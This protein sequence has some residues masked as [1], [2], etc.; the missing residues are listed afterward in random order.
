M[1]WKSYLEGSESDEEIAIII[2]VNIITDINYIRQDRDIKA[3]IYLITTVKRSFSIIVIPIIPVTVN[4]IIEC[5]VLVDTGAELNMITIDVIDRAGL[6]M[7][8]R[9]KIKISLYS[10][11]INRFL[12]MIENMLISVGLVVYRV[13]I[14]VTRLISQPFILEIFYFYSAHAQLLFNNDLI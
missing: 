10:E 3:G 5:F 2:A 8:T 11:Y 12:R 6:V 7:R 14:F 1:I 4:K 9:V 13:N